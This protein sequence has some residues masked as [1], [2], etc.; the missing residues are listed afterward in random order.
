MTL[1]S[2][3]KETFITEKGLIGRIKKLYQL[4]FARL[5]DGNTINIF[6]LKLTDKVKLYKNKVEMRNIISKYVD[7]SDNNGVLAIFD[8][9]D[10]DYRLTFSAKDAYLSA[11]EG[12]V[13][14]ETDSKRY[15]YLLGPNESCRTPDPYYYIHHPAKP[16]LLNRTRDRS[17]ERTV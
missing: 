3:P 16:R 5:S 1:F 10:E 15:T 9:A 14:N 12:M 7:F 17:F 6:E 11:T 2:T 8:S 13:I 4:G